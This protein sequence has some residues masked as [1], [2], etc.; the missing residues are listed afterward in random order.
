[1][2]SSNCDMRICIAKVLDLGWGLVLCR[3]GLV[4][5]GRDYKVL[6]SGVPFSGPS[7]SALTDAPLRPPLMDED[8]LFGASE[9]PSCPFCLVSLVWSGMLVTQGLQCSSFL[10][11]ILESKSRK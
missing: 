1:M 6:G 9:F 4:L 11:S 5:G 8:R 7:S 3:R 2:R 10:G